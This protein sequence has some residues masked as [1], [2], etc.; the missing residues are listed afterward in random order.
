MSE[1][2]IVRF[3]VEDAIAL[4]GSTELTD[5]YRLNQQTGPCWTAVHEGE[6][7]G[8]CGVRIDGVAEVWANYSQKA[9][10][11]LKL[12]MLKKTQLYLDKVMRDH[13]LYRLWSESP[14]DKNCNFIEHL[15]FR[16]LPAYLRG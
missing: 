14:I 4:D 7:V 15:G 11:D 3:T 5:A 2:E 1:V 8:C 13:A 16:K 12:S 10:N 6:I 9:K